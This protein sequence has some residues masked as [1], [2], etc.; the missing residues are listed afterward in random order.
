MNTRDEK[1]LP[2]FSQFKKKREQERENGGV[3]IRKESRR[4]R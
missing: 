1:N 2:G 4:R 3:S